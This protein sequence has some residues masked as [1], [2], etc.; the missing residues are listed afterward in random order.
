MHPLLVC[1]AAMAAAPAAPDTPDRKADYVARVTRGEGFMPW[2]ARGV[3]AAESAFR[4]EIEARK[5]RLLAARAPVRHPVLLVEGDL[6]RARRNAGAADWARDW[7]AGH[8]RIADHVMAQPDGYVERMVSEL[9]PGF[10]YA[11]TCPRCVGTKSQE[12]SGRAAWDYRDPDVIRCPWCDQ[13]YPSDATPETARLECPRSGQ[14]FTYYLNDEERRHP[15]DRSG[16]YA[17]RWVGRPM[18]V[19]F[20][21][22]IRER[23]AQFM[24]GAA[25]SLALTY[26]FTEDP[27][28]AE[29]CAEVLLRLAHC[30]R[31]WLYH[32]YWDTVADCDPMYAAYHDRELPL[33]WK[34]HLCGDAFRKDTP[35]RAAMLQTYWGA[36]RLHPSCDDI[37]EL[38]DVCLAYDLTYDAR[39]AAGA[40]VWSPERRARVE[41]DLILE[42]LM[43]GEPFL[44]GPGKATNVNNKAGRVYHPMAV[45]AKCLGIAEW[46][47][48]ALRGFEAQCAHAV[49]YD[50]FSYESPAYTFSS[51]SYMGGL[52]RIA[53]T[54]HGFR[55][56]EG[57]A[58]RTGRVDLFQEGSRLGLLLRAL[59]DHLLP[60]GTM[61][62]LSDTP[63]GYAPDRMLVEIGYRRFP[64]EFAGLFRLQAGAS[65]P[66]EYA[67]LHFDAADLGEARAADPGL[68]LSDIYFPSWMTALLRHGKGPQ[69][70]TLALAFSPPGGHRHADNL[71]LYY[72]AGGRALLGDHGYIGD[73]PMN[74]WIGSTLSHNL[75]VV[76]GEEQRGDRARDG[77]HPSLRLMASTPRVSVVEAASDAYP[78]CREYR[79]LVALVK[80]PDAESFV[81]DVFRVKG[82]REHA[83]R[84]FSELAASDAPGGELRFEGIELPPEPPL[85]QVGGS[86]RRD[87]IFGLRDIRVNEAPPAR[88]QATWREKDRAYR[89]WMLA[90]VHAV[91]AANGPG[92]QSRA[93]M[94][95]RVRTV[96][97]M[98]RGESLESTFVAVHEP[99]GPG[100]VGPVRA[101]ERLAVPDAAG[102]DAVAL[103][104]ESGWG[105]YR[106]FVDFAGGARVEGIEFEGRFGVLCRTPRGER[107]LMAAGAATLRPDAFGFE[108]RSASWAGGVRESTEDA[109]TPETPRPA[110]WTDAPEGCRG[111]LLV[112]D[113][114]HETGF[115]VR[116]TG[117]ERIAVTRFPLPAVK[118]FSLPSLRF[119]VEP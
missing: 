33:E 42:W 49:A 68:D 47:D 75:V 100:G 106:V 105:T 115:P 116:E 86:T 21:G 72:R 64:K 44:G 112:H 90:P 97:A 104:I 27:R 56:P 37:G 30:Y 73:S 17:W 107:W 81:V 31:R 14:A 84:V 9:T 67:A 34:R 80:G 55:W 22:V 7:L 16:R 2:Q 38:V 23:K 74:A 108:G 109:L 103:R 111:Y 119:V 41:R 53:E 87:D 29:R 8:R 65:R 35:E 95:R 79:R 46:A 51:A 6:Q 83:Y 43:G 20:S 25:R 85:P 4:A 82:G 110:D 50:G 89:L 5:D 93:Q 77:R 117:P 102:P 76:D 28:Y 26:R 10:A 66:S 99:A 113:G 91:A 48:T 69:A 114:S 62:P 19:S 71:A 63:V 78:Q 52:L 24:I 70:A 61:P 59:V 11:F 96:D 88:W 58:G 98:R 36:G 101:I 32:D 94:G 15:E 39:D 57:F 118:A 60:D 45:V 40:P 13:A 92:Q 1:L 3:S 18:H 54:L 12:A